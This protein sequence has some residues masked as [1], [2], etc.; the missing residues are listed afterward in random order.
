M[1]SRREVVM[2][3][4]EAHNEQNIDKIL[5]HHSEDCKWEALPSKVNYDQ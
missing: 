4:L 1:S 2:E 3:V 5:A